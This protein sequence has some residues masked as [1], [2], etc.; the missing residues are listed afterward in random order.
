MPAINNKYTQLLLPHA[1]EQ[2]R[3]ERCGEGTRRRLIKV[4][5]FCYCLAPEESVIMKNRTT[6]K[7]GLGKKKEEERRLGSVSGTDTAKMA[8]VLGQNNKGC[9]FRLQPIEC[10]IL[11]AGG[12]GG[13]GGGCMHSM[14]T[15]VLNLN[16]ACGF[17][18][19]SARTSSPSFYAGRRTAL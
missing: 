3:A 9:S 11:A 16:T 15:V 5:P 6:V 2:S 17:R 4:P 10:I 14:H 7:G 12:G 18:S 1:P 8:I 19:S 13:A